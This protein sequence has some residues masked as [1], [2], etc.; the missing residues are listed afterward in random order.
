MSYAFMRMVGM[1][2]YGCSSASFAVMKEEG[3]ENATVSEKV[4]K[5]INHVQGATLSGC[6]T[7]ENIC[8]TIM[9]LTGRRKSRTA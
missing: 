8:S 3:K 7:D 5:G 9:K 1:R 2:L 6:L 4:G